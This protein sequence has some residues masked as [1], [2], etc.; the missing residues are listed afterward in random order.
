MFTATCDL[1]L[2]FHI[3]AVC[4]GG[5]IHPMGH[6]NSIYA[7]CRQI[8]ISTILFIQG[9]HSDSSQCFSIFIQKFFRNFLSLMSIQIKNQSFFLKYCYLLSLAH[10]QT[11]KHDFLI[12]PLLASEQ[13]IT[14]IIRHQDKSAPFCH[15]FLA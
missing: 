5:R 15:F 12:R 7:Q 2:Q 3:I 4:K 13:I 14:S 11:S 10:I 1:I 9:Q 6:L 8:Y